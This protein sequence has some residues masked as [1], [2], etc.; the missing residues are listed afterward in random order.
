MKFYERIKN[1]PKDV[2]FNDLENVLIEFGFELNRISGSHNV[3]SK[4]KITFV[5]PTHNN[6]VKEIYVKRVLRIIENLRSI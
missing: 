6:K 4:D 5:I 3:Y 1:N 2:R